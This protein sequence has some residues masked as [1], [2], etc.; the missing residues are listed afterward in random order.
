MM[1]DIF[2]PVEGNGYVVEM[3]TNA[4]EEAKKGKVAHAAVILVNNATNVNARFAGLSGMEIACNYGAD[5]L[6]TSLMEVTQKRMLAPDNPNAPANRIYYDVFKMPISFDFAGALLGAEMARVREGAE[7]PLRV[8]WYLGPENDIKKA[9]NTP[10]REQYFY[11]ICKPLVRLIGAVEDQGAVD[12]RQAIECSFRP[13]IEGYLRGEPLPKLK[14]PK[15]YSDTIA[16]FLAESGGQAPVTITLREAA[17]SPHRNS[18]LPEWIKF[19]DWLKEQGES[20]IFL[21]DTAKAREEIPDQCTCYA[22]SENMLVRA[23]LYE[24][25]KANLFVSNGPATLAHFGDRPWLMFIEIQDDHWYRA[26][27]TKG[28]EH[29]AGIKVGSQLPWARDDQRIIWNR[30]TFEVIR[31]AWQAHIAAASRIAA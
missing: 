23:A 25:A 17:H 9:L 6:K 4:L 20:V 16:E 3:L 27:T 8:A 31:D 10:E 22:A 28:F 19:A 15:Q 14:A 30:D 21:R 18:N 11:G 24:H 29:F 13:V 5:L 12:G 2:S 1:L 7:G 26:G